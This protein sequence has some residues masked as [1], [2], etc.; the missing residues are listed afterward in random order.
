LLPDNKL[1]HP[2]VLATLQ[3][4]PADVVTETSPVE[5]PALWLPLEGEMA[6]PQDVCADRMVAKGDKASNNAHVPTTTAFM[7]VIEV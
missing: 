5:V 2:F 4:Q 1:I 3:A 6:T 7:F